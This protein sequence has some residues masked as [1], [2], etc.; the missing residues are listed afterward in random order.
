MRR[1][2]FISLLGG[3]AAWPLSAR[4]QRPHPRI[5]FLSLNS[6]ERELLTKTAFVEGLRALDY[7]EGQT[8]EIHYRYADGDTTKLVALG[9]QLVALQPAVALATVRLPPAID[10]SGRGRRDPGFAPCTIY[11]QTTR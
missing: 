3:A 8:I 1:R 2:E 10:R 4:A 6:I 9:R 11:S 7:V 5:A